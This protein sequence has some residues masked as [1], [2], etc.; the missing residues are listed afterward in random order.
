MLGNKILELRKKNSLSQETLSEKIGVTRQTISNW[1]LGVTQPNPEQL[2][3]LSKEFNISI[4][5]LLD[6]KRIIDNKKNNTEKLARIII[7][8]LKIS[9]IISIIII[10]I[11]LLLRVT[12][13]KG[14]RSIGLEE[15]EDS[16]YCKIYGEEHGYRVKYTKNSDL[17][18]KQSGDTYFLDILNLNQ[19]DYAHQVFNIIND[20]VKK[21]EGTCEIIE[22]RDLSNIVDMQ[23]KEGT[24]TK[25]S[26]TIIIKE[27]IDYN[28]IYGEPFWLEKYNYKTSDYEKLENTTGNNCAFN[29][30]AYSV[31]PDKP[32][33]LVQDWSC[34]YGSLNKGIYRIVK[35]ASFNSDIPIDKD[36][37]YYIWTEFE[38]T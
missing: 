35:D 16:I 20:Y 3:L 31:T 34:M 1:E 2:K 9:L 28:I 25:N 37:I 13:K 19:Y 5:E 14:N 22:N 8:Y 29:L 7:I 18:I 36:D 4:D 10:S 30:P 21:Q 27:N 11:I 38:I 6:N 15:K 12:H 23:I 17:I 32:L 33:E 24:L 26:L